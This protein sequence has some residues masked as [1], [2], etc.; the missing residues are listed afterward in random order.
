MHE[1]DKGDRIHGDSVAAPGRGGRIRAVI[2][3][4][5]HGGIPFVHGALGDIL[6]RI[7]DE[8]RQLGNRLHAEPTERIDHL[9]NTEPPSAGAG[10]VLGDLL[11]GLSN[12]QPAF[13]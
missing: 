2:F 5:R 6:V 1:G 11:R 4:G 8:R 12:L 13:N 7:G 9:F 10:S 3:N